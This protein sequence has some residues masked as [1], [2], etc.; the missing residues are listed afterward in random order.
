[1][2]ISPPV[3]LHLAR[4]LVNLM[5]LVNTTTKLFIVGILFLRPLCNFEFVLAFLYFPG[6]VFDIMYE[7]LL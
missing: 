2:Q 1:M 5:L 7:D 6:E 4:G 3:V